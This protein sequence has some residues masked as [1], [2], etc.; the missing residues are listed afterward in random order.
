MPRFWEAIE[1]LGLKATVAG[2]PNLSDFHALIAVHGLEDVVF[3][4]VSGMDFLFLTVGP[5]RVYQ[6]NGRIGVGWN[7]N[8]H[9]MGGLVA[10][11]PIYGLAQSLPA[12]FV[13][14]GRLR[15]MACS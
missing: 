8:L 13:F 6:E 12:Q 10:M 5:V 9:V 3:G 11:V 1:T 15:G 14:F 7:L 2:G 4:L